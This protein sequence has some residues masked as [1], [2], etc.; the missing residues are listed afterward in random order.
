MWKEYLESEKDM[1]L[2]LFHACVSN[3]KS[4]ILERQ[5]MFHKECEDRKQSEH[6]HCQCKRKHAKIRYVFNYVLSFATA[7]HTVKKSHEGVDI[8]NVKNTIL[9][10]LDRLLRTDMDNIRYIWVDRRLMEEYCDETVDPPKMYIFTKQ[11]QTIWKQFITTV[12]TQISDEI[13]ENPEEFQLTRTRCAPPAGRSDF[14]SGPIFDT[15]HDGETF[16]VTHMK[17]RGQFLPFERGIQIDRRGE[18]L[19]VKD[20]HELVSEQ[21]DSFQEFEICQRDLSTEGCDATEHIA[22]KESENPDLNVQTST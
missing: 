21:L 9:R 14:P 1:P 22:Q 2:A 5:R 20:F 6:D 17:I 4:I 13:F 7:P 8:P 15:S 18:Y 16:Y 10:G 19:P 11:A 3:F 12:S